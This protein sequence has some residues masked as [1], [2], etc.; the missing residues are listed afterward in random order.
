[1]GES[2]RRK[3]GAQSAKFASPGPSENDS[4]IEEIPGIEVN[5]ETRE[6]KF[7]Q[8]ARCLRLEKNELG[9]RLF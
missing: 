7:G 8:R 1:M 3:R 9:R 4:V 5:V 6:N 2:K